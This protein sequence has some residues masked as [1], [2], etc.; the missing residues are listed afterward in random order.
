MI[1]LLDGFWFQIKETTDDVAAGTILAL[2]LIKRNDT[3]HTIQDI[4]KELGIAQS[5]V[6]YQIKNKIL[7]KIK[8]SQFK[9]VTESAPLI[10]N[11]ID[12]KINDS[13]ILMTNLT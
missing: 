8:S 9:T 6:I 3:S 2:T 11:A 12:E 5:S 13:E 1:R 10:I 4:C 7:K